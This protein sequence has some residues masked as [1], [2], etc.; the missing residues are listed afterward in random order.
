MIF[1]YSLISSILLAFGYIAYRLSMSGKRQHT[2]NRWTILS[3][4]AVSIIMPIIILAFMLHAPE[5]EAEAG[6]R[7]IEIGEVTGGVS[8]P[9]AGQPTDRTSETIMKILLGAYIIG[10]MVTAAYFLVGL[11]TLWRIIERGERKEF[12]TFLLIL[13][14]DTCRTAPFSWGRSIVMSRKDYE[15]FG[16]MI[17]LHE[18]SHLRQQHWIDIVIAYFTICLQWYNPAA[19][20]MREEL[21][22]VHEY[23]VDEMV[24]NTGVDRKEYQMMLLNKAT[25]YGYQSFANSLNHSKLQKR[26]TMMYEKKASLRR[27]LFAL[28]LVPA[29]G[30]GIA[31]TVIPS[32]ARILRAIA[33]TSGSTKD[34]A[35]AAVP[36]ETQKEREVFIA[37]EEPAEFP[38]GMDALMKWLYDHIDYPEEAEKAGIQ[39]RVI[40]KFVIEAD[41]TVTHPEI[42]RGISPEVDAEVVRLMNSMPKWTPGKVNGKEVA[43]YFTLPVVFRL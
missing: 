36:A 23:Q 33:E 39:G 40:V 43:S 11:V 10:A 31:V 17:L 25:G 16:D 15:E 35:N 7:T 21:K 3:I 5:A 20:G 41:G 22:A 2:L 4:Y 38:D 37:V 34:E 27:R 19:W 32:V 12:G 14:E 6:P 18:H 26:I 1:S 28:T 29:I 30:A 13:A 9:N 42:V 8:K 24:M